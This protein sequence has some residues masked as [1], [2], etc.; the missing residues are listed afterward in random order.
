MVIRHGAVANTIMDMN[1]RFG[2]GEEDRILGISSMCFDLSV[3]DIFGALSS[4]R[5]WC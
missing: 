1:E 3:Y 4:G 5:C 2:V